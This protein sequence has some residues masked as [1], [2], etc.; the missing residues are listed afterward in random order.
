MKRKRATKK[1]AAVPEWAKVL[2][3]L[4]P[5]G[6][7]V[8]MPRHLRHQRRDPVP[9]PTPDFT[10]PK[11]LEQ[12]SLGRWI[13]DSPGKKADELRSA[14]HTLADF[15]A[16][17]AEGYLFPGGATGEQRDRLVSVLEGSYRRG[18]YLALLRYADDLKA[19]PEAA[20]ILKRLSKGP[21]KGGEA[22]RKKAS[23]KRMD[24]RRRFRELRKAG[25]KPTHARRVIHEDTGF[26][27]RQIERD[28]KGLS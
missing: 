19:V 12:V 23:P 7:A 9:E 17:R 27:T 4:V 11:Y 2:L 3:D 25:F 13:D 18:F 14:F 15:I 8:S 1:P 28:T 26:S 20:A 22:T 24:V 5:P 16:S 21:K 6:V 10:S